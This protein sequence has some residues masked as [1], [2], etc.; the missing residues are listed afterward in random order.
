MALRLDRTYRRLARLVASLVVICAGLGGQPPAAHAAAACQ[1]VAFPV[2]IAGLPYHEAGT[3]C[4]GRAGMPL[5]VLV[6][7]ATYSSRYWD[8]PEAASYVQYAAGRGYAVLNLDRLGV[9]ASAKPAAELVTTHTQAEALHQ[10]VQAVRAGQLGGQAFPKVMTG[11]HSL[12]AGIAL[13]EA[14]TYHDSD[15]LLLE[16]FAHFFNLQ[17][18]QALLAALIP[19][20]NDTRLADR[21]PGY[22]TTAPGTRGALFYDQAA[23]DPTVIRADEAT[24]ETVTTGELS[25]FPEVVQS[26]QLAGQ[27]TVPTLLLVGVGEPYFCENG[28]A[29]VRQ[30][31][32][33]WQPGLLSTVVQQQSGHD[34]ALQ[35]N[36]LT[37]FG[38]I[39]AWLKQAGL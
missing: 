2:T 5:Q 21:P 34:V 19:A 32:G 37:A 35:R 11:G 39:D 24:K 31:A 3:F 16:G 9:G 15:A 36:G 20:Q 14:A 1:A 7:G 8:F 13:L 4:P 6:S 38:Q 10:V 29:N 28:C 25:D 30:E 27:I 18:G 33:F 26:P 22:L 17:G 12:G 23:A